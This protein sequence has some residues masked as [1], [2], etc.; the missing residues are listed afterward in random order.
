MKTSEL[1]VLTASEMENIQ[2]GITARRATTDVPSFDSSFGFCLQS[3][4]R[5]P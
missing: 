5:R 1:I 3:S 4:R 2:G